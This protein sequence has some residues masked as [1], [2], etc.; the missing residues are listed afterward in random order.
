M[1]DYKRAII[2]GNTTY[3]KGTVQKVE[4]L[5]DQLDFVTQE[6]L[7]A[8]T[9]GGP[10]GSLKI[11]IQKFYR[12]NGGSTQL[13][14]V[15]PDIALPNPYE[16]DDEGG[17]R[18]EKSAL[19]WDEIAPAP[20]KVVPNAVN[21]APL[22]AMSKSRVE[23]NPTFTLIKENASRIKKQ[24]DEKISLNETKYRKEVDENTALSKKLDELQKATTPYDIVNPKADMATI[25]EDSTVVSR[26]N[27]WIK[28]LK[29]DIYLNEVVNIVNDMEKQQSSVEMKTGMK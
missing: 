21:V 12:I 28:N 17:E 9:N 11:T 14:G 1:Q 2:V 3:G 10:I 5:D 7:K 27:D 15:T 19:K 25:N 29:K 6:K 18:D 13:K 26:N 24:R 16:M 4:S 8:D 23:H 22:A 20:Y